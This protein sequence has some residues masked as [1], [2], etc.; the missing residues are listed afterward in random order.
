MTTEQSVTQEMLL[1][2]V[3][4]IAQRT[5]LL[6]EAMDCR[7]DQL[8]Q[9]MDRRL[10]ALEE[11]AARIEGKVDGLPAAIF[12]Q[13]DTF[14]GVADKRSQDR[15]AELRKQFAEPEDGFRIGEF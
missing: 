9:E 10:G 1:E 13:L 4:N 12:Q 6:A 11:R 8:E 3:A 15:L 7:F 14:F 2:A 5:D